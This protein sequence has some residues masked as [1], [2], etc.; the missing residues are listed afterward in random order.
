MAVTYSTATTRRALRGMRAPPVA[1]GALGQRA[2]DEEALRVVA[3][4]A[5][6]LVE[7]AG[8]LDA[9]GDG[10]DLEVVGEVDRRAHQRAVAAV[11]EHARHIGPVDLDLVDGQLAKL[12]ERRE[13]AAEVVERDAHAH[14]LEAREDR[15]RA[16]R[17]GNRGALRN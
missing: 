6:Q 16:L 10:G 15:G 4:E 1:E 2:R 5:L 13:A 3:P 9:F 17:L 12:R 7:H 8:R 11:P 14:G